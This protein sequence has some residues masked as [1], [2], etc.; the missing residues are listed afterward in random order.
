MSLTQKQTEIF[1]LCK[2]HAIWLGIDPSWALAIADQESTFG[3]NLI[4]PTGARGIYQ[5]TTI[6][7]K[8]ILEF[9]GHDNEAAYKASIA[10]GQSELLVLLT[11][12]HDIEIATSHYCDPKV[13]A[14]YVASVM[15]KIKQYK[16]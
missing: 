10:V 16:S 6:A 5:D 12:W 9:I 11:R 2:D 7:M 15:S 14:Q 3:L 8:D 1:N 13:K 4:S